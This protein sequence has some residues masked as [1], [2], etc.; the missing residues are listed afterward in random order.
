MECSWV[1][2]LTGM[3]GPVY[4]SR[5]G[6]RRLDCD[7]AMRFRLKSVMLSINSVICSCFI[8]VS[9][10]E[11]HTLIKQ[12]QMTLLMPFAAMAFDMDSPLLCLSFVDFTCILF[13]VLFFLKYGMRLA[14]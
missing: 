14:G 3:C 8:K 4:F 11:Y 13:H 1:E 7:R 9:D 6:F 2:V 5:L 12:K 10:T